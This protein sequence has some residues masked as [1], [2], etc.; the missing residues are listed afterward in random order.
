[1][2]RASM[3]TCKRCG[4]EESEERLFFPHGTVCLP[5]RIAS[6][7]ARIAKRKIAAVEYAK[8]IGYKYQKA[9]QKKKRAAAEAQR[10]ETLRRQC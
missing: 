3:K 8:R 9:Y 5:C 10:A 2:L 4:Q 1:M 7:D 6:R